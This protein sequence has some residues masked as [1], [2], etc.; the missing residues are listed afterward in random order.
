M[1][2]GYGGGKA[3]LQPRRWLSPSLSVPLPL[4]APGRAEDTGA[5]AEHSSRHVLRSSASPAGRAQALAFSAKASVSWRS[6]P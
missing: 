2:W 3:L 4:A 5:G 1:L 6:V